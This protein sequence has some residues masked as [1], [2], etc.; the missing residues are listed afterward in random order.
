AEVAL[1]QAGEA[2]AFAEPFAPRGRPIRPPLPA[3][4]VAGAGQLE[5]PFA[6]DPGF[7]V[8]EGEPVT[9][10]RS[11]KRTTRPHPDVDA[12]DPLPF[13]NQ[14]HRSERR[15]PLASKVAH[16]RSPRSVAALNGC[17]CRACDSATAMIVN[18]GS[19]KQAP[20]SRPGWL[21]R[22]AVPP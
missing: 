7:L 6:L 20:S 1:P 15:V 13:L 4:R 14:V 10:H 3:E 18:C 16:A 2:D 12:A 11:F 22:P 21:T 17:C 19:R 9:G 5:P 8:G